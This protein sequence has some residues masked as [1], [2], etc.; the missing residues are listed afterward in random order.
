MPMS[1]AL[2]V[3]TPYYTLIDNAG[4]IGPEV[5]T[6]RPEL[7]CTPIY[8]FSSKRMY[9]NFCQNCQSP[10]KPYPLVKNYLRN[11]LAESDAGLKLIAIDPAGPYDPYL[12]AATMKAVLE[13][14][15]SGSSFVFAAYRLIL[16]NETRSY[17]VCEALRSVTKE[18][19]IKLVPPVP[20]ID[21]QRK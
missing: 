19:V 20:L 12:Y 17:S 4:R 11:Q 16:E 14:Q 13:S 3:S 21:E 7:Q 6:S 15:E 18:A 10:L 2:G 5:I 1:T 9:D 8:A